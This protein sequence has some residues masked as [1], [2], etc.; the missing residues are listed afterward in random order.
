MPNVKLILFADDMALLSDNLEDLRQFTLILIEYLLERSLQLNFDKCKIVKFRNKGRGRLR[1][2]D[3]FVVND[4]AVEFVPEFTYLGVTFQ[5]SG[6]SFSTHMS[7][8]ARAAIFAT[9]KLTSLS[10]SSVNTAL[11]LFDLAVAPIASYGIQVMWPYLTLHDL[12]KLE[13]VKSRYLK[14][15]LGLSKFMKSRLTYKLADTDFFV[16]DL[17]SRFSLPETPTSS[18]FIRNQLF[19]FSQIEPEI[20]DTPA[21]VNQTWKAACYANRHVITRHACH[22]FHFVLCQTKEYHSVAKPTCVCELCGKSM[23]LYHLF[24]CDM[25][26]SSLTQVAKTANYI[27][28]NK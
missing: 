6:R 12:I 3:S 8:K 4:E 1:K 13:S 24:N 17:M 27:S 5:S 28:K 22:G 10:K 14:K 11:K 2:T 18:K 15:A 16:K 21:M 19:K 20:Y 26:Q 23:E 7:K 25:N 9:A